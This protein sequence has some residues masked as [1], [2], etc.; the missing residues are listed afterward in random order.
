[1][2]KNGSCIGTKMHLQSHFHTLASLSSV[3][4]EDRNSEIVELRRPTAE[5]VM[6]AGHELSVNKISSYTLIP[7]N[8]PSADQMIML[9]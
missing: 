6:F 7:V 3:F 9:C 4:A 1:M 2:G 5:S 8:E